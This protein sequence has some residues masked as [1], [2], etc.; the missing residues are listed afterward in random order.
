[1][2]G[3]LDLGGIEDIDPGGTEVTEWLALGQAIARRILTPRGRLID[4]PWYGMTVRDWMNEGVTELK[5]VQLQTAIRLEVRKDERVVDAE[6]V[7]S[8]DFNSK[9]ITIDIEV[10]G[11]ELDV[12]LTLAVDQVSAN[13]LRVEAA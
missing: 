2:A 3:E 6:V 1:M 12:S 9:T 5:I 13:L 10:T 11:V 8:W 4:D 7:C